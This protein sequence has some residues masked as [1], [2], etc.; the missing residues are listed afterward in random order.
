MFTLPVIF[1]IY[2]CWCYCLPPSP[3][4]SPF[5][6]PSIALFLISAS[7]C[8]TVSVTWHMTPLKSLG[9]DA[10]LWWGW[11]ET[12]QGRLQVT[13]L[14]PIFSFFWNLM[15]NLYVAV[16]ANDAETVFCGFLMKIVFGSFARPQTILKNLSSTT[17]VGCLVPGYKCVF[18]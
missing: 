1:F 11:E 2:L 18:V 10:F 3:P 15:D 6:H 8:Q 5:P 12:R 13:I 7:C 9:A 4:V 16:C 17:R 14:W